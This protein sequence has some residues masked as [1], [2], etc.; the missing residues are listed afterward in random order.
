MDVLD[1]HTVDNGGTKRLDKSAQSWYICSMN[2]KL[3]MNLQGTAVSLGSVV[4]TLRRWDKARKLH[5]T[6]TAGHHRR[7]GIAEVQCHKKALPML[8]WKSGQEEGAA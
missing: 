1:V 2:R 5:I 3:W 4:K 8:V 7:I 6:R